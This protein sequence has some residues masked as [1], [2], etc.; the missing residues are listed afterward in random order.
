MVVKRI[1][2]QSPG[3]VPGNVNYFITEP[4]QDA[5]ANVDVHEYLTLNPYTDSP[6]NFRA[7]TG[8]KNVDFNKM[9]LKFLIS[10]QVKDAPSLSTPKPVWRD[11][12]TEDNV[13]CVNGIGSRMPAN[14]ILTINNVQVENANGMYAYKAA[15]YETLCH[16]ETEKKSLLQAYGYY[17]D[18]N[19]VTDAKEVVKTPS[20]VARREIFTGGKVV[21]FFVPIYMDMCAQPK[22]LISN[23][24]FEL[25]LHKNSDKFLAYG[26]EFTGEVKF[27]ISGMRLYIPFVELQPGF[28]LDIEKQLANQPVRYNMQRSVMKSFFYEKERMEVFQNIDNDMQPRF[29][30]VGHVDKA[31]YHGTIQS[32]P[33]FFEHRNIQD[34]RINNHTQNPF[35]PWHLDFK[36]GHVMRAFVSLHQN[37]PVST[38]ITLH[39]FMTGTTLFPQI[40]TSNKEDDGTFD[41]VRDGSTNL[42]ERF[43]TEIGGTGLTAVIWS[44]YDSIIF[45]DQARALKSDLSV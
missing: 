9:M 38:G 24:E 15:M 32:D 13:A 19:P 31:A 16:T 40:L 21:E 1:D 12:K 29:V 6:Y 17:H 5:I 26:P 10:M 41:L 20:F 35:V 33:F 25:E 43:A 14:A 18:E 37:T 23:S 3:A 44:R 2:E 4:T 22:P 42:H 8:T 34:H 11:S 28:S 36:Q 27:I 45:M 7:H 30:C 39:Q